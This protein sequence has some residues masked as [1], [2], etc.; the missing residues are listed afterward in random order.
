M[1]SSEFNIPINANNDILKYYFYFV[2]NVKFVSSINKFPTRKLASKARSLKMK[3]Y[4]L[5]SAIEES[6][7]QKNIEKF[8]FH[9]QIL[10]T[11]A[12]KCPQLTTTIHYLNEVKQLTTSSDIL[13]YLKT[14]GFIS[15][16]NYELLQYIVGSFL[17]DDL[18]VVAQMDE[19]IKKYEDFEEDL[20]LSQL[21]EICHEEDLHPRAPSGLPEFSLRTNGDTNTRQWR[22]TYSETFP[23]S[24]HTLLKDINP[25]SI[26]MTYVALP[27]IVSDVLRDLTDPVILSEL[28]SIGVTVVL[29]PQPSQTSEVLVFT[30]KSILYYVISLCSCHYQVL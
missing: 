16:Q 18:Q 24:D 10:L 23:W 30:V 9:V 20:S 7:D 6:S 21:E 4:S 5:L 19:Y 1:A 11:G 12:H 26:I 27:C 17:K 28:E 3:F 13:L 14:H 25:G 2:D 29:L 8:K 22:K 15:Y